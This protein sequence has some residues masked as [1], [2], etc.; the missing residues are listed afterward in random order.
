MNWRLPDD[1]CQTMLDSRPRVVYKFKR[2]GTTMYQLVAKS[3]TSTSLPISR[4][5]VVFE[6][7][8]SDWQKVPL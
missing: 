7:D 6:G 3:L 1:D 2:N 8:L 4:D 5:I